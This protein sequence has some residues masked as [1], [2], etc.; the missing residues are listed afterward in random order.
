MYT[1]TILVDIVVIITELE[2]LLKHV[3]MSIHR[4]KWY[5]NLIFVVSDGCI[6]GRKNRSVLV[7]LAMAITKE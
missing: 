1:Y 2:R 3:L 5:N 7:K 4:I 6:V